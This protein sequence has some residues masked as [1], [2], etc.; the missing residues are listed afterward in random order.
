MHEGKLANTVFQENLKKRDNLENLHTEG[1]ILLKYISKKQ[2]GN[3]WT[4]LN[5]LMIVISGAFL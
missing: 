4:G 3:V 2:N 1:K 5:Q